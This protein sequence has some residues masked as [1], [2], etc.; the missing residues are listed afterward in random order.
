MSFII[1]NS[2]IF[3]VYNS[4]SMFDI[5]TE[6]DVETLVFT[7]YAKVRADEVLSPVFNAVI[8]EEEWDE[9]LR[10]MCN[11]WSTLLLYTRKYMSDPMAKHLPLPLKKEHFERW[12]LLFNGTVTELF[13]GPTADDARRRAANIARLMQA[14]KNI[15]A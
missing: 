4:R 2:P 13:E 12:L 11:F 15:T 8:R 9:H 3:A 7:F 5:Q 6:E 10:T 14:T 1:D